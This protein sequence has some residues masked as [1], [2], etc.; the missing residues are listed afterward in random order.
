[1]DQILLAILFYVNGEVSIIEGWH[2]REQPSMDVCEQRKEFTL[3]SM[4][5][6]EDFDNLAG[7]FCGTQEEIQRQIDIL[8]STDI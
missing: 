4:E 7:V 1:M 2:P 5:S 6:I 3:K 8:N